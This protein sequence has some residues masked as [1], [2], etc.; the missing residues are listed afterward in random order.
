MAISDN[1]YNRARAILIA[2]GSNSAR[3][4]HEKHTQGAGSPDSH[5]QSL[6]RGSRDEFRAADRGQPNLQSEMTQA[7]YN[8]IHAAAQQMGIQNW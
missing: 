2:A 8:A 4:S 5:G 3:A 6:L 7:H 1:D